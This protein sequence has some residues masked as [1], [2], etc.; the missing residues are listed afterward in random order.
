MS[1]KSDKTITDIVEA[2]RESDEK[3]TKPYDTTAT[4]TRVEDGKAWVHIP[5]GVAETPAELTINAKQG[6][7]VMVRV[8]GGRAFLLGNATNPPT[9]DSTA[10]TALA[11]ANDALQ[12]AINARIAADS[13]EQSAE[14]A[15]ASAE[16]ASTAAAKAVTDAAT[17]NANAQTAIADAAAAASAASQAQADATSAGSA[18]AA[19]Q[20]SANAAGEAASRAQAAADAAQGEIDDQ[21]EY[22]WHDA[23]GAHVL[24]DTDEVTG[25]RYRT[26]LRGAGQEIFELD[27]QNET[28]VARFGADGARLGETGGAHSIVDEDGQRFY[29][30]DGTTQLANIGYGQGASESGTAIA[31]YYTFGQRPANSQVGNY[32]VAEGF[33]VE[34]SGYASHAEGYLTTASENNSHAEGYNTTASGFA[35]HAEGDNTTASYF[36]SHA[37]G[38]STTASGR[39]S[40]AEGY[41]TTA[42]GSNSHAQNV[43]TKAGYYA[44]TAIGK[45]NDNKSDTAFE[46]G[47]GTSSKRS[48]AHEFTWD[49]DVRLALDT[50]ATSGTD[51]EIY[52]AL[53]ALGWA[54]DVIS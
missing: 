25:K 46:I 5:G 3:K 32:S 39:Y 13:A 43:G 11:N 53:V 8:A 48:N 15:Q 20:T 14:V 31:P 37:E 28:S 26:D 50:S 47:N 12:S 22:F 17:A 42:S 16:T 1:N 23:L 38:D 24:S 40:H 18:A 33:G 44:Q 54:S 49:G 30:S 10:E 51:K 27:G 6:D 2:V 41:L 21:Q 7:S 36:A 52:D 34:A 19:A 4:V 35:S 45:Y 29:A 9:D